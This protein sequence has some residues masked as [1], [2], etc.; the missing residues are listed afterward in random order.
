MRSW[1]AIRG[2]VAFVSV[3]WFLILAGQGRM[4]PQEIR[5]QVTVS[6]PPHK[7][8][9]ITIGLNVTVELKIIYEIERRKSVDIYIMT[10]EQW[11]RAH[12]GFEPTEL[13][14]DFM[15]KQS[16]VVGSGSL[17]HVQGAGPVTISFRNVGDSAI[18]VTSRVVGRAM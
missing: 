14:K 2:V 9:I 8:Y 1:T 6:M 12:A 18:T 4:T 13:G 10:A 16:V 7:A 3:A 11:A 17:V 5:P 15:L